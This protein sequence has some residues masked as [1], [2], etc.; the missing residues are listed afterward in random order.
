MSMN[1]EFRELSEA[2]LGRI[3]NDPGLIDSVVLAVDESLPPLEAVLQA[4]PPQ[5]REVIRAMHAAMPPEQRAIGRLFSSQGRSS[6]SSVLL[7]GTCSG[8]V[9][10]RPFRNGREIPGN[11]VLL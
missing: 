6:G 1:A 10:L 7:A 9:P 4:L 8:K 11:S 5:Q 3:R 2:A